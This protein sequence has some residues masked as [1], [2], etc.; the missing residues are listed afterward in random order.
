MENKEEKEKNVAAVMLGKLS[1]KAR[2]DK[3]PADYFHKISK[4]A[5]KAKR[6]KALVDTPNA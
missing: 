6:E 1:W 5:V 4:K 3:I 2:K